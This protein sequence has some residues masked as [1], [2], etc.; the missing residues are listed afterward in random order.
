MP[1]DSVWQAGLVASLKRSAPAGLATADYLEQRGIIV[2]IH[3]QPTAA[4]WTLRRRI[5]LHPRY[6]QGPADAPYA[7]SLVV[8]EARHLQ[9][10]S[11]AA[12]S[13]HGEMDAWQA[14]FSFL[15]SLTGHYDDRSEQNAIIASLMALALC[16]DRDV[17][18][19]ARA[20]MRAFAGAHYRIDLL[21]LFPLHRELA[22]RLLSALK[23]IRGPQNQN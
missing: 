20:L 2:G 3:E 9:Q 15:K 14:Q 16:F 4:R 8:H 11:L 18:E 12:L 19:R 5:E 6:A 13:V 22:F 23:R 7:L 10:G 17:L 1:R 21:P